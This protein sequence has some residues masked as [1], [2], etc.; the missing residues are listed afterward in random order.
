MINEKKK[1]ELSAYLPLLGA[2]WLLG[3]FC[4]TRS[5]WA[6]RAHYKDKPVALLRRDVLSGLNQASSYNKLRQVLSVQCRF[7][8]TTG[9]VDTVA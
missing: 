6:A 7:Y 9:F 2:A 8:Q 3:N 1:P 5:T 4:I